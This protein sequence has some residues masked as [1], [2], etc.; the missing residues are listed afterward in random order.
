MD[1]MML[2]MC[3]SGIRLSKLHCLDVESIKVIIFHLIRECVC[4]KVSCLDAFSSS[5]KPT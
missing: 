1:D 5:P 4:R 3:V 2:C